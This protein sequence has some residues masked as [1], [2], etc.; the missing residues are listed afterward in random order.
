MYQAWVAASIAVIMVVFCGMVPAQ[1]PVTVAPKPTETQSQKL[2]YRLYSA[3]FGAD[4]F[5]KTASPEAWADFK[6]Q[7]NRFTAQYPELIK[8]IRDSPY[9]A[10]SQRYFSQKAAVMAAR[11]TPQAATGDCRAFTKLLEAMIDDPAGKKAA[12]DYEIQLAP[13]S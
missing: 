3:T 12:R 7:L 8:L 13:R 5:C 10:Q 1:S 4:E 11:E 9:Y 6:T 2:I